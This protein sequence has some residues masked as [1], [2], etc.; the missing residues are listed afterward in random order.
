[1]LREAVSEVRARE[2]AEAIPFSS[3]SITARTWAMILSL[4]VVSEV[5]GGVWGS[6]T[7]R[8]ENGLLLVI[9]KFL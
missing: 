8:H 9:L 6:T 1:M 7:C 3:V 5:C 4:V 2:G